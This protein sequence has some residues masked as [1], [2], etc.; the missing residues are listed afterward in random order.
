M[1]RISIN[2]LI[3]VIQGLVLLYSLMFTLHDLN[4]FSKKYDENLTEL[5]NKS[6]K[7]SYTIDMKQNSCN[8]SLNLT[9]NDTNI[10]EEDFR[11][12]SYYAITSHESFEVYLY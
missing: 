8:Y 10:A 6:I 4:S 11:F 5:I 7:Y 2:N 9:S 3:V 12:L 1:I